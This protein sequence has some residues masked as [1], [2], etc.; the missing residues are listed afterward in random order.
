MSWRQF[1]KTEK[2]LPSSIF[3]DSS[4]SSKFKKQPFSSKISVQN[5]NFYSMSEQWT[6]AFSICQKYLPVNSEGR[7]GAHLGLFEKVFLNTTPSTGIWSKLGMLPYFDPLTPNLLNESSSAIIN[8]ILGFTYWKNV[9]IF[10]QWKGMKSTNPG[11]NFSIRDFLSFISLVRLFSTEIFKFL[12][13]IF[14]GSVP[15]INGYSEFELC[16]FTWL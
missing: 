15:F 10:N 13:K 14:K 1:P 9:W 3:P 8:S 7:N 2:V 11:L 6:T 5:L 16:F 4:G 12:I